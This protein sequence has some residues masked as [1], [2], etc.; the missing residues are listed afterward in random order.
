MDHT[1]A[2]PL[3]TP[4]PQQ[5]TD[6][7]QPSALPSDSLPVPTLGTT[8]RLVA[9]GSGAGTTPSDGAI[10]DPH[11]IFAH[12]SNPHPFDPN[13]TAG[14]HAPVVE[15]GTPFPSTPRVRF[16]QG[17]APADPPPPEPPPTTPKGS[18]LTEGNGPAQVANER[19]GEATIRDVATEQCRSDN[20]TPPFVVETVTEDDDSI[21]ENE[22]FLPDKPPPGSL[23]TEDFL[24]RPP[25]PTLVTDFP[26]GTFA[27]ACD[28]DNLLD[29]PPNLP[30]LYESVQRLSSPSRVIGFGGA[31]NSTVRLSVKS[32]KYPGF[33]S[34][35]SNALFLADGGSNISLTHDVTLLTDVEDIH[36]IPISVALDGQ[37]TSLDYCCTKKGLMPLTMVDGSVYFQPTFYCKNATESIVSPQAIVDASDKFIRWHQ[38][39]TANRWSRSTIL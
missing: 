35:V 8:V 14:D 2:T 19:G 24:N 28:M 9:L 13:F 30:N 4:N 33:S 7:L 6:G 29:L 27:T 20:P 15:D 25:S 31:S 37:P 1:L 32:A 22:S 36:P 17:D 26:L 11:D 34:W 39:G 3:L 10:L 21:E 38:T 16:A 12:C 23:F 18:D 5:L